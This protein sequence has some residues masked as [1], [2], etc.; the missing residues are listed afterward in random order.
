MGTNI[1]SLP[2]RLIKIFRVMNVVV[3]NDP[4]MTTF[5]QLAYFLQLLPNLLMMQLLKIQDK[6]VT[7]FLMHLIKRNAFYHECKQF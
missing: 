1:T 7:A 3:L 4:S 5:K 6:F 2:V